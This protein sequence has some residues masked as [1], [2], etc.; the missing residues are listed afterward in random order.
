MYSVSEQIP[1]LKD[2]KIPDKAPQGT[3]QKTNFK[4]TKDK[5]QENNVDGVS[6]GYIL[7]EENLIKK[8]GKVVGG[9]DR[10]V[11]IVKNEKSS[12]KSEK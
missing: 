1:I 11:K 2:T 8:S 12:V 6:G 5:P 4:R 9:G 7:V 3:D 10:V